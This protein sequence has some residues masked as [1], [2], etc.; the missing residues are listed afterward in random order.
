M[1]GAN[2]PATYKKIEKCNA[3]V[4]IETGST[5]ADS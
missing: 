4:N 3:V 5:G 2:T 1:F